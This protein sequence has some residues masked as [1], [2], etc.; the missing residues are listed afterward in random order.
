MASSSTYNNKKRPA[1]SDL[2]SESSDMKRPR[3]ESNEFTLRE[4]TVKFEMTVQLN[5]LDYYQLALI[6]LEGNKDAMYQIFQFIKNR[7]NQ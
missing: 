2:D 6:Y 3:L 5:D 1:E 4:I 7:I